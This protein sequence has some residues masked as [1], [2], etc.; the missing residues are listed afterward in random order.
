MVDVDIAGY[1]NNIPHDKLLK[2][3]EQRVSDRRVLKLIRQWLKA[4][5]MEDGQVHNT[6]I[7]S[8]QGGVISP[9]LANIYLNYLD[10]LWEKQFSHI[11]TLVR[12]ADDLVILCKN[13]PHA[14]EAIQVLKAVFRKLELT[15][16]TDKSKL[17]NLWLD[18][19]GFDF[20]RFHQRRMPKLFK[21]GKFYDLRSIP[22]KKAMK[23]M[24]DKVKE[25]TAPRARLY[26]SPKQ[27]VDKLNPIIEGWK[28]Y[29]GSVDPG[30]SN[31]FLLKVDW[32]IIRRLTLYW[33]KKHKRNQLHPRR[34]AE[35]FGRMG[36][37]QVSAWGS[38]TAQGEE[39]RKAVC[40]KTAR[41]V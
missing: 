1:F 26:W 25:V 15:M 18:K 28:N 8:P 39:H 7:G 38:Y 41:T 9:L 11:G 33:N 14:M 13:K 24:R 37:K 4:G 30:M 5:V 36:L 23:K 21:S 34:V 20:L 22:S 2:L 10:T 3:V 32:H 16:N 6:E 27:M 29:Y 17:V 40:G 19:E 35:V 31:K 12:Y